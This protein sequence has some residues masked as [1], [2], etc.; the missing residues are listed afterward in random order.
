[1]VYCCGI[2]AIGVVASLAALLPARRAASIEPMQALR[3]E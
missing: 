2:L 1:L 3:S